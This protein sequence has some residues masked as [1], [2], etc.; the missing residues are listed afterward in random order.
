[1]G[2]PK[3]PAPRDPGQDALNYVESM[4]DPVLQQTLLSSERQYRPQYSAL[5]LQSYYDTTFGMGERSGAASPEA[6]EYAARGISDLRQKLAN[7]PNTIKDGKFGSRPNPAYTALQAQMA[8]AE[9]QF[10]ALQTQEGRP[11]QPGLID[12]LEQG[13]PRIS[14]MEANAATAQRQADIGDVEALGSRASEAFMAANPQLQ[15]AL[16]GAQSM[17]GAGEFADIGYDRIGRGA[18][19][20][21][22]QQQ[23][24]SA[25]PSATSQALNSQALQLA[26]SEGRLSDFEMRDLQQASRAASM[27]RGREMDNSGIAGELG[28][29]IAAQ[30]NRR[31]EDLQMASGLNQAGLA[32][33]QMNRGFATGV[34]AQDLGRQQ[35]NSQNRT[36]SEMANRQFAASDRAQD[37]GYQLQ[38]AGAFG[39]YASDPFMAILGRP[40][41]AVQQMQG[42]QG[43]NNQFMNQI[44]PALFDPGVGINLGQAQYA[45]EAN[46]AGAKAGAQGAMIGGLLGGLGSIAGGFAGGG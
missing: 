30:R 34:Q 33:Q 17:A 5:D 4:A 19:G 3:M 40:S 42:Q 16:A 22:L 21:T 27:S 24:L 31:M 6:L 37:R 25:G 13:V 11:A 36:Q 26:Q 18:L 15:Q 14:Q 7:T 12:M 10:S 20:D 1:M 23:A 2:S 43:F 35:I 39:N 46:F 28:Q 8:Q 38:L 32:E 44:G 29:R 41:T 45:N 9:Q